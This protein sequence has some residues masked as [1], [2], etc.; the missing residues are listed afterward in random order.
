MNNKYR[1]TEWIALMVNKG[2]NMANVR[3]GYL[4]TALLLWTSSSF[5]LAAVEL[6]HPYR[7]ERVVSEQVSSRDQSN[8]IR[9]GLEEV[10]VRNSGYVSVLLDQTIQ[11]ALGSSEDFLTRYQFVPSTET[12][13]N[14][15]G[16]VVGTKKLVM[17]FDPGLISSLLSDNS[18]SVWG[19]RRPEVLVWLAH[20][21]FGA[22]EILAQGLVQELEKP[23]K[24]ASEYRGV[25]VKLPLLDLEDELAITSTDIWGLFTDS[26]EVASE[27]YLPDAILAGRIE[28]AGGG[29]VRGSWVFLFNDEYRRFDITATSID[30]LISASVDQV[31]ERLADQYAFIVDDFF[32]NK[33]EIAIS[34]IQSLQ[35]YKSA[36]DYISAL[37]G[38]SGVQLKEIEG[39][40]LVLSA[41]ISGDIQQLKDIIALD[42]KLVQKP[43]LDLEDEVLV[44]SLDRVEYVWT[45]N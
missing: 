30:Q 25:P 6:E 24:E 45:V 23:L 20:E 41:E 18:Q 7:A 27:R 31:A 33:V 40:E 2:S 14:D 28:N 36:M 1:V 34:G 13:V 9:H 42:S 26:I 12:R 38:V 21:Q 39:Q 22:R 19:L 10:L 3:L 32:N 11:K 4:L 17:E 35:N 15:L 8:A 43:Q 29:K 37:T 44:H 16:E 5:S